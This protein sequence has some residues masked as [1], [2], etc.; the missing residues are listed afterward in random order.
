[1]R[2]GTGDR[3]QNRKTG[4]RGKETRN[5]E[6]RQGTEDRGQRTGDRGRETR[7]RRKTGDR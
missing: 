7:K 6:V 3:A 1:M 2:Q 5:R 4:D